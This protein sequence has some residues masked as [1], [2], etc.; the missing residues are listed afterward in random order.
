MIDLHPASARNTAAAKCVLSKRAGRVSE[1]PG[2]GCPWQADAAD[3]PGAG[4]Q[5]PEDRPPDDPG[6]LGDAGTPQRGQT[7][8]LTVTRDMQGEAPLVGRTV[9]VGPGVLAEAV[10]FIGRQ[11]ELQAVWHRR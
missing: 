10:P 9:N 1:H 11:L 4:P 2:G 3:P 7:S 8:S 6:L 5:G